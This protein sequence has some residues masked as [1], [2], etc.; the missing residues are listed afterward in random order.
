MKRLIICGALLLAGCETIPEAEPPAVR[1]PFQAIPALQ[2]SYHVVRRGETL[3]RIA[4]S[5]GLDVAAIAAANRLP[6]AATLRVGQKLFLP[7]PAETRQ[8]LWP[9]RGNVSRTSSGVEIATAQGSLVRASRGG[10]VAVAAHRLSGWGKTV[11]LDHLDGY[12]SVY[13]GLDQILVSPGAHLRQGVPLGNIG[14]RPLH[15]EIRYGSA[16]K[17][18]LA[19]LPQE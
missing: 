18:T 19:F 8:F 11:V 1:Q 9:V 17:N 14:A 5:Y 2:G 12:L 13:A 4:H 6:N 16:P 10:R 15:F 3:W 7:L